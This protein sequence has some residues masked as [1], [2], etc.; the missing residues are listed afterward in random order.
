LRRRHEQG[1]HETQ[2]GEEKMLIEDKVQIEA[3]KTRSY[4]MGEID[5]KVMITQGRYIV[6]VKKEDFLLDIDKQKKLP[7][8]GVKHFS[9]ENIQSQMRAAKLS[10]RMLTTGKSIL[11][12]IRDETTGEYAW[13]DNKYLKMF[14][15]CTPNLIKYQGNPEHYDAVFTRYGEIIGIILPVRV[16]EW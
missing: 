6:F 13:F 5:G 3:V 7:E 4:M 9:T 14:D 16:S 11:R 8:D 1:N 15:G 12:A 2:E 10:N